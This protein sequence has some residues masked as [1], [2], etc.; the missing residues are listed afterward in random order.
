[1]EKKNISLVI[2]ANEETGQRKDGF[3]QQ[4]KKRG[5]EIVV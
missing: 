2:S 1:M 5:E 4:R 3:S